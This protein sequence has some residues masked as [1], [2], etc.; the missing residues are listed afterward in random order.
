MLIIG[1]N[2]IFSRRVHLLKRLVVFTAIIICPFITGTLAHGQLTDHALHAL[3]EEACTSRFATRQLGPKLVSAILA[4]HRAWFVE[5]LENV[6]SFDADDPRWANLCRA[7]LAGAN[8]QRAFLDRALMQ[9][10]N[11]HRA[12]LQRADLSS[13]NLTQADLSESKLQHAFLVKSNLQQANLKEANLSQATADGATLTEANLTHTNLYLTNFVAVTLRNTVL[14]GASLHQTNLY[15]AN[16]ADAELDEA[17]LLGVIFEPKAHSLPNVAGL[18]TAKNLATMSFAT[19]PHALE[20]L[21]VVLHQAGMLEQERQVSL[22]IERTVQAKI[23]K[24]PWRK[25]MFKGFL[26]QQESTGNR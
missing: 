15:K 23:K 3:N 6:A 14:H 19:F 5:A 13:A 18:I 11:L 16:M 25:R 1:Q 26:P 2:R 10:T 4:D 20:A 8:L 22:A 24:T 7:N 9:Q 21:R 17:D 12:D